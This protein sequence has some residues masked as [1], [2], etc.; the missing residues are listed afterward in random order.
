[1]LK[2]IL[3][4]V[5]VINIALKIFITTRSV[6]VKIV[7]QKSPNAN[8]EDFKSHILHKHAVCIVIIS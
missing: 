4:K 2:S 1:M 8:V 3:Y 7:D 5:N 6:D